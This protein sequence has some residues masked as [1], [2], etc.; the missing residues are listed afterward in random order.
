M[1]ENA[2]QRRNVRFFSGKGQDIR[3]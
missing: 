1:N 2:K 3:S